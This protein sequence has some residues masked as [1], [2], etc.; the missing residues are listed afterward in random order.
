MDKSHLKRI[1]TAAIALPLLI[2]II[3]WTSF[4]FFAL[5]VFLIGLLAS[6]EHSKLWKIPREGFLFFY[7]LLFTLVVLCGYALGF[8]LLGLS[9]AFLFLA[10]YFIW[11]YGHKPE[12]IPFLP[13]AALSLIYPTLFLGHAF[14]FLSLPQGRNLLLWTL[15]VVFASDTGAFYIGCNF[16]KHKLY[17]AVSP[18]KS[19]EGLG[20]A[21]GGAAMLGIVTAAFLPIS[22]LKTVGLAIIL[23]LM[24]QIGDF[25]ESV[26]KRH[27][28]CKDSGQILPGHG[29]LLDRIDGVLFALPLS[30]YCWQWLLGK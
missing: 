16:G 15:L 13:I 28:G 12:L 25:F 11:A 17:P 21:L 2:A 30:Y 3:L 20:G 10:F 19:W 5:F 4:F 27:A 24:E 9:L 22:F 1:L 26:I 14:S 8:P 23:A 6:F 29:G 7:V 18:K